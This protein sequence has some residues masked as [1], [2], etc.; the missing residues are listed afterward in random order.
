MSVV[1]DRIALSVVA[2]TDPELQT[3]DALAQRMVE[4]EVFADIEGKC[5]IGAS[6]LDNSDL[7]LALVAMEDQYSDFC[8]RKSQVK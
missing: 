8:F 1:V 6:P 2:R 3:M 7:Q 5:T 4:D